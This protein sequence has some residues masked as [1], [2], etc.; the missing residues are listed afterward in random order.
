MRRVIVP[1]LM[2]I[3]LI[4]GGCGSGGLEKDFEEARK[5][6]AEA[7]KLSFT[8]DVTAELSGSVFECRLLCT[9][10]KGETLVEVIAPENISG[11]KARLGEGE[12]HIE[13]EGIILAIG[14]PTKG[15]CSPISAVA[16]IMSALVEAPLSLIWK[17]KAQER[18]L[19]AG[20]FYVSETE[21][22]RLWFSKEN[23]SL[24]HAELVSEGQA[25]VK[26]RI[27]E[28]TKE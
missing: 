23:Y 3:A 27:E 4:L 14:D 17:E 7:E 18:E 5:Q 22:A 28:F 15:E 21:S 24:V 12:A 26:C 9:R 16:A 8:A 20:E 10:S 1:A 11:I 6:L 13:Y 2:I 19:I 25:V